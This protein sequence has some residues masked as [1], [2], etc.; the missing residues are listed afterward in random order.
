MF[1]AI[2]VSFRVHSKRQLKKRS[3]F[4]FQ[5]QFPPIFRVRSTSPWLLS[6]TI[7]VYLLGVTSRLFSFRGS[8]QIFH[9][10]PPTFSYGRL[11]PGAHHRK[12]F[13]IWE[14]REKF[15]TQGYHTPRGILLG[16]W[17]FTRKKCLAMSPKSPEALLPSAN[18]HN[19]S[20]YKTWEFIL[21][22]TEYILSYNMRLSFIQITRLNSSKILPLY[23]TRHR[24]SKCFYVIHGVLSQMPVRKKKLPILASVAS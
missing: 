5:A 2:K 19:E 1:Q 22:E 3:H 6:R 20:V 7:G 15:V 12:T 9:R 8:I 21:L 13:Y 11:P 16:N 23:W 14:Y 4:R 24:S 17:L 10:A 18:A